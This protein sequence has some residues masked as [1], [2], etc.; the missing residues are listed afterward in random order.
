MK[1][2]IIFICVSAILLVPETTLG[3]REMNYSF[4][5]FFH[6]GKIANSNLYNIS[7]D[8]MVIGGGNNLLNLRCL[9]P[10]FDN[11][12][13]GGKIGYSYFENNRNGMTNLS[14]ILKYGFE[15]DSL[16]F[17]I[18]TQFEF[19]TGSEKVYEGNSI[20]AYYIA[21]NHKLNDKLTFNL[22]ISRTFS[23]LLIDPDLSKDPQLIK[24]NDNS[25]KIGFDF[26]YKF[27]KDISFVFEVSSRG[28]R[29]HNKHI[30]LLSL[31]VNYN[32]NSFGILRGAYGI[33]LEE[34]RN[35]FISIGVIF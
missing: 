19:E 3:Q 27:K 18:G 6:Q 30:T 35:I 21:F 17:S 32:T 12:E 28:Y 14:L 4:Q 13:I 23:G 9:I 11:W 33:D 10:V 16:F 1:R 25:N 24:I 31:G 29:L 2:I 15:I 26:S 20:Q 34:E 22:V 5:G 7:L 8:D